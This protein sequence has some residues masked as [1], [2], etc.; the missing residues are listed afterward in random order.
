MF[1]SCRHRS[2]RFQ[3]AGCGSRPLRGADH[4]QSSFMLFVKLRVSTSA[5]HWESTVPKAFSSMREGLD[6][7]RPD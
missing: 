5:K 1:P 6:L 3:G 4:G 2:G 7:S